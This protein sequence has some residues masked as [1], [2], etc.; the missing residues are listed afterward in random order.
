MEGWTTETATVEKRAMASFP[1][2]ASGH[3]AI[4]SAKYILAD[5]GAI[6]SKNIFGLIL[7]EFYC[8]RFLK[9]HLATASEK[10]IFTNIPQISEKYIFT[11]IPHAE[12]FK[13]KN[14][15]DPGQ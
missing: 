12:F 8:L 11:N 7:T 13:R 6:A 1:P 10:Y 14:F 9:S 2:L 15:Q 5:F 3:L 4:A